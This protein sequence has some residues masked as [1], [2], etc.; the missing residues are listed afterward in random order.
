MVIRYYLKSARNDAAA[1]VITD[2]RGKEVARLKGETAAGINTVVWNMR[3]GAARRGAAGRRHGA[4]TLRI[5]GV[6]LGDYVVTLEVG[7]QKLTQPAQIIK[8]QGWSVGP[9]Y[10]E[11]SSLVL[12][13]K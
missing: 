11:H 7:G 2:S 12:K 13:R 4:A 9:A 5:N 8:T 10:P 3:A 6:P 1:I